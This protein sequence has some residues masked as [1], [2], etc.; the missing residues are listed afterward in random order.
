M[1]DKTEDIS[2]ENTRNQDNIG[3]KELLVVSFG[4]SYNDNRRLTIGA[5]EEEMEQAFPD[6]SIRRGFTSQKIIKLLKRRDQVEIDYVKEALERAV[7]NGVKRLLIQPTH[8]MDGFEY[9][10]LVEEAAKYKDSFD[11]LAVGKPLLDREEDFLAVMKAM[12]A[13]TARYDDGETA[14][15]FM[16]H[17]TEAEAN[18]VYERLQ[19]LLTE[20]G[21]AN[22]FVGTVEASP[23]L[24]E[25][26]AK[27]RAGNYKRAVL[28]PLMIVAGDHAN[29]DMAGDAEGSWKSA[30]QRAGYEVECV[31]E[32][33]GGLEEIRQLFVAHARAAADSLELQY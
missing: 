25:V 12:A 28:R 32:G 5:I 10:D 6:Y 20:K 1:N 4:T 33:M 19:R 13:A 8:L 16:G 23:T 14:V 3:E 7:R 11:A 9:N 2:V 18:R 30:F 29:H 15:C 22:Y 24:E 26:L 27:V 21:F 17:G 31:L